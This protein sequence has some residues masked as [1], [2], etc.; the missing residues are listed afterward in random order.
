MPTIIMGRTAYEETSPRGGTLSRHPLFVTFVPL[1]PLLLLAA[2][3]VT[4]GP[5][6]STGVTPGWLAPDHAGMPSWTKY[7]KFGCGSSG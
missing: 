2:A 5:N 7:A 6:G 4:S 1:V 3:C